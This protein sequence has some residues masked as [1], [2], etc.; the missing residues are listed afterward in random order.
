MQP[1]PNFSNS[2]FG[3]SNSIVCAQCGA[4]MPKDMRFCRSCG[5]RLGEGSAEY[6][7]TVRLPHAPATGP[8]Y[9]N[10]NPNFTAPIAKLT[11]S[12]FPGQ[13][14]RRITGM[15][16]I[17]IAIAFFFVFGGVMSLVKK[18][19][20]N[21]PRVSINL[22]RTFFGVNDFD[23]ASGGT[24]VTFDNVEP[25]GSP[26]DKAGLVGGDI[27]TS[28]DGHLITDDG[29]LRNLLRQ[30]PVGKT[31]E[32][33]YLRDGQTAKT[34][35]TMI[36][37][38]EFDALSSAFSNRPEG[39]G[40]FGFDDD[41]VTRISNP[42]TKTYGVRLDTVTPNGPADLFGIKEGDII[43]EFDGVPIRTGEELL[44][45]VRRA[46]PKSQVEITLLRDGQIMKIPVT[47][48]RS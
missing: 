5:H 43:T 19:V 21:G 15:T 27:I 7:E 28:F 46:I 32:V 35:V 23:I 1:Q 29:Q 16:W 10:F 31:V 4:P 17:L 3:E 9:S 6:T 36:S 37:E 12:G 14:K 11:G 47:I 18:S 8:Q 41:R 48:G 30:T 13:R 38:G 2:S 33:I 22:G 20:R 39:R 25:P 34:Q 26:A 45:R 44:S 42:Q 40:K 24:G